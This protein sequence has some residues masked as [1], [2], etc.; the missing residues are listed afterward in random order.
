V[1]ARRERGGA[2]AV[3]PRHRPPRS[4]RRYR[5]P[6]AYIACGQICNLDNRLEEAAG[7]LEKPSGCWSRLGGDEDALGI[8]RAEQ[9][10][11]AAKSGDAERALGL[12]RQAMES[13]DEDVR[14]APTAW[15]ATGLAKASADDHPPQKTPS[16]APWTASRSYVNGGK[17]PRRR[18]IGLPRYG[19]PDARTRRTACSSARSPHAQEGTATG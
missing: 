12:A 7:H 2:R 6:R 10:K 15:Y 3:R 9:A 14:Y 4:E 18:A 5:A 11:Q 19:S 8:L 1:D 13:L 16:A 17:Q